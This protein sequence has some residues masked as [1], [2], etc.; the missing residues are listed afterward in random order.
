MKVIRSASHGDIYGA[1][2]GVTLLRVKNIRLHLEFL[3]RVGRWREANRKIKG[4]VR[5]AIQRDLILGGRSVYAEG[6][7]V[8][9]R[10]RS[11]ELGITRIDHAGGQGR[12]LICRPL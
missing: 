3:H 6:C 2:G 5:R 9:V 11:S 8:P 10:N 12:E 1:A 4:I 7:Q